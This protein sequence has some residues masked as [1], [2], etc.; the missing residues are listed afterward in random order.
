[1]NSLKLHKLLRREGIH[2]YKHEFN[3]EILF[4]VTITP[5]L[6]IKVLPWWLYLWLY[7]GCTSGLVA[8][9]V[10]SRLITFQF[11]GDETE[12]IK[13]ITTTINNIKINSNKETNT[14]Q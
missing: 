14:S 7:F 2:T 10:L 3:S 11:Q 5:I 8:I 1:M 12:K 6:T 9:E 4:K 13:N